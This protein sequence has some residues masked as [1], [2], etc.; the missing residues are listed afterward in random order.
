MLGP[1]CFQ[2]PPGFS[3]GSCVAGSVQ[4]LGGLEVYDKGCEDTK[5]VVAALK[6]KGV[7]AIGAAGF[8][9][10]GMVVVKL[11]SCSD[12][13]AAVLLHPGPISD[14][15]INAVKV[16]VAILG[17]EN[18]N[19][20][21][22]EQLKK[23]GEL[24]SSKPEVRNSEGMIDLKL[25]DKVAAAGFLV[26]VPDLLYG[27]YYDIDNPKFDRASWLA[28]HGADKGCEDT[29]PIIAALKSK[30]VT[31]IGA[32]GFCWGVVKLASCSDIQAAVLLHPGP[33]SDHEINAV[34]VPVAILGAEND[35]YFS[36]EQLK[37]CGE[38]LSSKP[39]VYPG[40]AHG[41][42]V[43]Y[44]VEDE[45][46]VKSAQEAHEDMLNWFTKHIK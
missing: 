20:F 15:E 4:E 31:A 36:P 38:L 5:P 11:A 35:N 46:A 27:D 3:S 6:S 1:E 29:K 14:H 10:G 33:I 22:P 45:S 30:G 44:N 17:A 32:A 7:T 18:D 26:V 40:V 42:T 23:C 43:R 12:I 37:K 9:W 24:L 39:E 21:S 2:K 25:A 16:P 13:Q 8:C 41:W 34:K 28:A 19:Y